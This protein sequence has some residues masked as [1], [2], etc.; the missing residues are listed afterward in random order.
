MQIE[1][2]TKPGLKERVR[3]FSKKCK[4]SK[5]GVQAAVQASSWMEKLAVEQE[6]EAWSTD[7][8]IKWT[9]VQ[10]LQACVQ[11]CLIVQSA[12]PSMLVQQA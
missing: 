3:S 1:A 6:Q 2:T 8:N 9:T 11:A 7:N 10:G 5:V 4:V 12:D